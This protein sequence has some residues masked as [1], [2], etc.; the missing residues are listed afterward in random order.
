MKNTFGPFSILGGFGTVAALCIAIS[1]CFQMDVMSIM[2]F[3]AVGWFCYGKLVLAMSFTQGYGV[4][5]TKTVVGMPVLIAVFI[6]AISS[7]IA[8]M[9]TITY[10]STGL[11]AG[12]IANLRAFDWSAASGVA[13]AICHWYSYGRR[14]YYHESEYSIRVQCAERGDSPEA[15]QATVAL[16]REHGIVR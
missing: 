16:L 8:L 5:G 10:S 13:V 6:A 3:V 2:I 1:L 7:L 12:T 15:A 11:S 14:V 4:K 9:L